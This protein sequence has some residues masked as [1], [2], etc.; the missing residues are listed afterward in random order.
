MNKIIEEKLKVDSSAISGLSYAPLN[1]SLYIT[2]INGSIYGYDNVPENIYL[3]LKYSKSIGQHFIKY[4]KDEYNFKK[5]KSSNKSVQKKK[6][7]KE[8]A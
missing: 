3:S 8:T 5:I 4:I 6:K 2:F 7:E 1:E